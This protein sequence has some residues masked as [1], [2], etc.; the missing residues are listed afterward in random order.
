[1][2]TDPQNTQDS[3]SESSCKTQEIP[4]EELQLFHEFQAYVRSIYVA[5][6]DGAIQSLQKACNDLNKEIASLSATVE[7]GR[8][9]YKDMFKPAVEHF[10]KSSEAMLKEHNDSAKAREARISEIA[11]KTINEC[12]RLLDNKIKRLQTLFVSCFAILAI[13]AITLL[14][15]KK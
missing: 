15:Y 11:Q 7:H 2:A 3:T 12:E 13:L 5:A 4:P 10:Q 1:M 9:S 6:S 14:L 8:D